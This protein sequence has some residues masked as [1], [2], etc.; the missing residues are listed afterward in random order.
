MYD[1][2]SFPITGRRTPSDW[3]SVTAHGGPTT[4]GG[5]GTGQLYAFGNTA[6]MAGDTTALVSA[7]FAANTEVPLPGLPSGLLWGFQVTNGESYDL[8]SFD[9]TWTAYEPVS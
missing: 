8:A 3:F 1:R 7:S 4:P 9:I 5:T 6:T 2:F